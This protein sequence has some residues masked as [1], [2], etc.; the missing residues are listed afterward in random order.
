LLVPGRDH[1]SNAVR[2][3]HSYLAERLQTMTKRMT[4]V[5]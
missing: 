1:L 3:L 5:R 4:N 2:R